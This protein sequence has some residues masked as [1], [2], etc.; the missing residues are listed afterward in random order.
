MSRRRSRRDDAL[1]SRVANSLLIE[2]I[3]D[4][5]VPGWMRRGDASALRVLLHPGML[6]AI[7]ALAESAEMAHLCQAD[8]YGRASRQLLDLLAEL[9]VR[10][11]PECAEAASDLKHGMGRLSINLEYYPEYRRKILE[12]LRGDVLAGNRFCADCGQRIDQGPRG[13]PRK[14]CSERCR[15]RES[16]RRLRKDDTSTQAPVRRI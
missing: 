16:G 8:R 9:L 12:Y 10:V 6:T 4:E 13:R 1:G 2:E 3:S 7:E 5:L 14:Y 11:D 15:K